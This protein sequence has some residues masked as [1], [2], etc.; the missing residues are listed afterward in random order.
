MGGAGKGVGGTVL[1]RRGHSG[2]GEWLP[3]IWAAKDNNLAVATHA[4]QA[5]TPE[6]IAEHAFPCCAEGASC[7]PA[8]NKAR[9]QCCAHW[10]VHEWMRAALRDG[11][12][13]L[14]LV[15]RATWYDQ[16][17]LRWRAADELLMLQ[18]QLRSRS[19][20]DAGFSYFRLQ[21]GKNGTHAAPRPRGV[22]GDA[23]QEGEGRRSALG[24]E[25][26]S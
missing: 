22:G 24:R 18:Q 26:R 25:K 12:A 14:Q 16:A 8:G 1:N 13:D 7:C 6:T 21:G 17:L 2:V 3:L 10:R 11:T 4:L 15:A 23:H 20:S 9:V 5:V 19:A